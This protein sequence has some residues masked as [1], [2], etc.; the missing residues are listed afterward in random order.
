[1]KLQTYIFKQLIVAL[2]MAVAGILFV[3]LPGIA[4]STVHRMP[5]ADATILLRYLPLV[6][7]TL[8]PH[9]LPICFILAVVATY[10]R[11]AADKEW[12]A[13][14]MAG[15]HPW[16]LLF[17]GF[18]VAAALGGFTYWMVSVDMPSSKLEQRQ[19]LRDAADSSLK[20]LQPGRTTLQFGDFFINTKW[21]DRKDPNILYDVHIRKPDEQGEG[22]STDV[23][24]RKVHIRTEGDVFYVDLWD[25]TTIT[26]EGGKPEAERLYIRIPI[27]K[28]LGQ[29][30]KIGT[31]VKY[32]KSTDIRAKLSAGVDDPA[33]RKSMLFELHYRM[34][35]AVIFI[36][37]LGIGAPTGLLM[38]RGTQLGALAISIGFGLIYYLLAV[39]L[40]RE[41]GR[42]GVVAPWV[43]AWSV[44]LLG[45][46][47]S[48]YLLRKIRMR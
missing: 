38:R 6:L 33:Q 18:V 25:A 2:A 34:S 40:G 22:R 27:A 5:N 15:I 21:R 4:V 43:G 46:I 45:F 37:F 29:T 17:P 23:F 47:V 39:R 42:S 13:M 35:M 28:L 31:K 48:A 1:M 32:L 41:L 11:L 8:A 20:N 9:A 7:K 12:T 16:K 24:A 44:P 19:L 30:G 14:L 3:A 26:A 10:G 36:V